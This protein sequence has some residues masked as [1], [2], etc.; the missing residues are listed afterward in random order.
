[1]NAEL[2]RKF[3]ESVV[4]WPGVD[5]PGWANLHCHLRND[6]PKKNGGKDFVI[7]WPSK[8]VDEFVG[9]VRW[10]ESTNKLFDVWFCTSQQRECT[11]SRG[12]KPKA[13]RKAANAKWLRSIWVDCDVKAKSPDW[14]A[15]HPGEPWPHYETLQDAWTAISAFTKKNGLPQP[16]ALVISGGGWHVY[17]ISETPLTPG[18][19]RPYAEG[20]KALLIR[21][22]VKCDAGL[23]TDCARLLRVPGTLN[24]K[25]SPPRLVELVHLGHPYNFAKLSALR[26]AAPNKSAGNVP[27]PSLA[28]AIEPGHE[29]SFDNGPDPAFAALL[30]ADDLAGGIV[31]RGH[32][33][34]DPGPV[35]AKC[36]FMSH[37]RDTGGADYDNP[38]WMY[39]VLCATFLHNG[40]AIA[41]E[42][43]KNHPSY[44][45][46]ETQEMYERKR[47][48]RA[49]RGVGWPSC[50][51][52]NGAGCKSC[53]TCPY[54]GL[55]R[56][57][58]HL[59]SPVTAT[60]TS[61]SSPAL[62]WSEANLR[63]TFSNI[64]HRRTLYGYD[65]VRREITVVGAPGG[66]GKT[67]LVTGMGVSIAIGKE[68]LGEKIY[69]SELRVVLI[70]AEDSGEEV[71]RRVVACCMAHGVAEHE[72]SRLFIAGTDHSAVQGLSLL[73]ANAKNVSELDVSGF[74]ALEAMLDELRPDL[75]VLDPL[76]ALCSNGNMNDNS[77]MAMVIR[78]LKRLAIKFDCA[79]LI[80]H[81]T[82]KGGEAGSAEAIGG[83]ASIVNLARRAIMPVAL[84]LDEAVQHRIPASE[85]WR[86]LRL[87][88]AKSNL[89]PRASEP[90]FYCLHSVELPNAE[91]PTYPFGDNVQAIVRV[92]LPLQPNGSGPT[93]EDK[94]RTA[95]VDLVQ[96]GKVIDGKSYPYSPSAAGNDNARAILPDAI[97]AAQAATSPRAWSPGD[98]EVLIKAMIKQLQKDGTLAAGA[99]KDIT[100]DPGRFRKGRGL[101]VS[102]SQLAQG[103]AHAA[104]P[105]PA[106]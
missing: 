66:V 2:Q 52:I 91:P 50:A 94:I 46:A 99:M 61:Q 73:R 83:A 21:E 67:T 38:L 37:A 3:L 57:P 14:D 9:Q 5:N 44:T 65:L 85:R 56:S 25:Y 105:K 24:H 17:W 98:L 30:G 35:F 34:L 16:S 75:L 4:V 69:G 55:G 36:G 22:G 48:D 1:M 39:S 6:D 87:V 78:G 19:W 15:T 27:S 95:I 96:R 64:R 20:L 53:T 43:S 10:V 28:P 40:N 100:P 86:Y 12:G 42:V 62:A 58:L 60:V 11:A 76:V 71:R 102:Q 106:D 63:V 47:T 33:P 97:T 82:R 74:S 68:L 41:H 101:H 32:V 84:T 49:E 51:T 13:V 93:D 59:T 54:L 7:G 8:T 31:R 88:D 80:V 29:S 45:P 90:A 70:N 79:I 81:H 26:N 23:T 89:A 18:E 77:S 72:L 104:D 92:R 103:G